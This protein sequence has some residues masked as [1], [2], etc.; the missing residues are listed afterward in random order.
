MPH[1]DGSCLVGHLEPGQQLKTPVKEVGISSYHNGM[2]GVCVRVGPSI[3]EDRDVYAIR[4]KMTVPFLALLPETFTEGVFRQEWAGRKLDEEEQKLEGPLGSP[5]LHVVDSS[6]EEADEHVFE[7]VASAAAASVPRIRAAF[8]RCHPHRP[9]LNLP[10]KRRNQ[11]PA[12]RL[13]PQFPL[14]RMQ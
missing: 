2:V 8:Y 4:S 13:S 12:E 10:C 6:D 14:P 9:V 1:A 3:F 5:L 7:S 11:R